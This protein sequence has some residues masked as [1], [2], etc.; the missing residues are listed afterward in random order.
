MELEI[1]K[2]FGKACGQCKAQEGILK[3]IIEERPDVKV[4]KMDVAE[5]PDLV[6]KYNISSLPTMLVMKNGELV[7]KLVGLKPKVIIMKHLS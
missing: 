6:E 2:F 7:E 5:H 4:T 1:I 3:V